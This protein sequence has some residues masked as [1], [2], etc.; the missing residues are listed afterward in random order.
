MSSTKMSAQDESIAA[1]K[2]VEKQIVLDED[3]DAV[4][5]SQSLLTTILY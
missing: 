1:E 4:G 3:Y 2:H 5:S